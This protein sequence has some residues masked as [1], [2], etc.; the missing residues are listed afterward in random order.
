MQSVQNGH[1]SAISAVQ[2]LSNK[3]LYLDFYSV[4]SCTYLNVFRILQSI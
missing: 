3:Y 2:N 4:V 1:V